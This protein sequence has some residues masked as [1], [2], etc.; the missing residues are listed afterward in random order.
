M[1]I[2]DQS[3]RR[4]GGQ[5][6]DLTRVWF[7]IARAGIIGFLK[8]RPFMGLLIF[9]WVPFIVRAVQAYT[10]TMFQQASMLALTAESYRSFLEQQN[11]FVFFV[12]VFVGAGLIAND[13]RANALQIYLSKPLTRGEYIL[14]KFAILFTFLLLITFL[15]AILLLLLQ[16]AFAGSF[17]FLRANL[18]VIPAITLF[19][20]VQVLVASL[21]MLA[22]S[23]MSN[24]SRFVGI[25]YAGIVLFSDAMFAA[26]RAI[27]GSSG[28]SWLSVPATL[29]QIGDFV[30]R[31]KLRYDTPVSVSVLVIVALV[32]VSVSVL[33]RK[34]RGVEVVT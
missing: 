30:F 28:M 14:G 19:S 34:V 4:Y 33:E 31:L 9:A 17:Q 16:A 3:Y 6:E 32:V 21:S 11:S 15:P 29:A 10:S 5:R 1:P 20:F 13:R 23:S 12:T 27:L 24:S 18:H 26:L 7:V 8:K 22:L 2:H 25:M